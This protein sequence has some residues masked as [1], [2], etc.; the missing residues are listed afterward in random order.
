MGRNINPLQPLL[1]EIF[2]VPE[3]GVKL[4]PEEM[5]AMF[6]DATERA[7]RRPRRDQRAYCSGKKES[8]AMK[9]QVVVARSSGPTGQGRR[10]VRIVAVC[11][12]CPGS[13]DDKKV[14]DRSRMV[15]HPGAKGTGDTADIGTSLQPPHRKPRRGHLTAEQRAEGKEIARRRIAAERGIGKLKTGRVATERYRS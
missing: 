12:T 10:R 4:E 13:V 3:R 1:A 14:Y 15:C 7:T 6:F 2:R 9:T 11:M 5:K 8:H